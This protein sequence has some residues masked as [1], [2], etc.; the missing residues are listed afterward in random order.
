MGVL[1][2]FLIGH[3]VKILHTSDWSGSAFLVFKGEEFRIPAEAARIIVH[4][5]RRAE[6]GRPVAGE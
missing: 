1:N 3:K 6:T 4:S 2:E 5:L